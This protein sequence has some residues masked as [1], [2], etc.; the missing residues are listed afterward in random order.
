MFSSSMEP[1]Q[2]LPGKF[3]RG[4]LHT[5]T[6]HEKEKKLARS[7]LCRKVS[8]LITPRC[9]FRDVGQGMRHTYLYLWYTLV[10]AQWDRFDQRN[11]QHRIN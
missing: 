3:L 10:Q 9:K 8:F 1:L 4:R 6:T 2:I 7:L 11:H 5:G